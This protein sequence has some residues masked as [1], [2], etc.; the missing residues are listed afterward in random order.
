MKKK[1]KMFIISMVIF[2]TAMT[3]HALT[4]G[5][6][7]ASA[8][9]ITDTRQEVEL[10][11]LMYH[12]VTDDASKVTDYT[13]LS[14][15]LEKDLIWLTQNG[16]TSVSAKQLIDYVENGAPLPAKPILLTFDDGYANNYTLAFPL[17]KK[18]NSKAII[19]IIGME[20]DISSKNASKGLKATY[21]S[22]EEI[23][24]LAESGL[25]EFANHTYAL[26]F[27]DG[28]R[29]GADK[30]AS[31]T[32]DA[33]AKVLSDDLLLNQEKINSSAGQL[34]LAFV[35]PY[36]AYPMDGSA[37]AIL[38]D[39]GFKLSLTSYQIKNTIRQGDS[40]SLLGLKRFLRTPDFDISKII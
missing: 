32:H 18:Y 36:G 40:D 8:P 33:Y 39:L 30:L 22:W 28:G 27:N 7:V 15:D 14:S 29:K 31:E 3:Y 23:S 4:S 13:I 38:K 35:W 26:H 34:P 25:I 20:S 12:G 16:Y 17:L 37:N 10:P 2:A 24:T 5:Y 21:L 1:I 6:I 19:S 9:I 11:I